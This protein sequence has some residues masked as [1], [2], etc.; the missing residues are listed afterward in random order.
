[1]TDLYIDGF[2]AFDTT[3]GPL[4]ESPLDQVASAPSSAAWLGGVM[5]T[6]VHVAL[7]GAAAWLVAGSSHASNVELVQVTQ[8]LEVPVELEPEPPPPPV[9]A[10]EPEPQPEPVA[11]KPLAAPAPP[12]PRA[13]PAAA[14]AAEVLA[15]EP[16]AEE[17]VD[18]GETFVQGTAV[19]YAGG[20]TAAAGTSQ[21]AVRDPGARANGIVGGTGTDTSGIDRSRAPALAGGAT[22]DCPFPREADLEDIHDAVVAL[23][24]R[25][26][27]D[28]GVEDVSIERDP[29]SG[30]GREAMR[31]ARRKRW[32][33]G[34]DAAG[35]P[36][37]MTSRVNVRFTR[38]N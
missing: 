18:F 3:G 13:A 27:R 37:A 25:V 23:R 9:A 33:P 26:A 30:F 17:I 38:S 31:C 11:V 20:S 19:A 6:A 15:Q 12:A 8:M 32:A 5:A 14:Q 22:W 35:N 29:G 1:M 21:K 24:V 7:A 16:V 36:A 10:P 34:L 4:A 2:A 28:G